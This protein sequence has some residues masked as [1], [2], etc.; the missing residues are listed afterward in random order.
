MIPVASVMGAMFFLLRCK[1]RWLYWLE[2]QHIELDHEIL[3]LGIE[4]LCPFCVPIHS[5]TMRNPA[6]SGT[7]RTP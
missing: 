4:P 6:K 5:D 7:T 3:V 1:H 2:D